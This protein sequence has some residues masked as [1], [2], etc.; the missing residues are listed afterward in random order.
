MDR[1]ELK[2]GDGQGL[3]NHMANFIEHI[4]KGD[5]NTNCNVGIA[6]NTARVAHLGNLALKTGQRLYWDAENSKFIGN[7]SAN[8]LLVPTYRAPWELPKV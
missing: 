1:V 4:K 3:N 8:E 6:A 5:Q 2:K 7:D